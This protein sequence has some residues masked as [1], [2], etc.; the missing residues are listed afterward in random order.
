MINQIETVALPQVDEQVRESF[1]MDVPKSGA[2]IV[3][4]EGKFITPAFTGI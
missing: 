4:S 2:Q 1:E 3:F